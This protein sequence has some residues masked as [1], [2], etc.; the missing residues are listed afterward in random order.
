MIHRG[1]QLPQTKL[2]EDDVRD[3]REELANAPRTR[4]G[5]IEYGFVPRLAADYCVST[6]TINRIK[7]GKTWEWL[8]S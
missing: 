4:A 1:E 7:N 5:Y 6:M 3:I 8:V 2:T